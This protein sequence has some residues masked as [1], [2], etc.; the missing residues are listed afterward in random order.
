MHL[1]PKRLS[2]RRQPPRRLP[3]LRSERGLK[4]QWHCVSMRGHEA[5]ICRHLEDGQLLSPAN[6]FV[7]ATIPDELTRSRWGQNDCMPGMFGLNWDVADLPRLRVVSLDAR[8]SRASDPHLYR[9]GSV[10]AAHYTQD[11]PKVLMHRCSMHVEIHGAERDAERAVPTHA[12]I[13]CD[14]TA[15][16]GGWF[17]GEADRV[18]KDGT[19]GTDRQVDVSGPSRAC[20]SGCAH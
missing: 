11:S 8:W 6:G 2:P 16:S 7:C 9:P 18:S 14:Y 13:T 12:I 4:R 17:T 3:G 20:Q 1:R 10:L 19:E 15:I 5:P